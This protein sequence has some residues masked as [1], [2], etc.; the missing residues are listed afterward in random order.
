MN[1]TLN[2]TYE[3]IDLLKVALKSSIV[4]VTRELNEFKQQRNKQAGPTAWSEQAIAIR[5]GAFNKARQELSAV[6]NK[7]DEATKI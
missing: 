5:I 3:E 2:L 1:H 7:L 6:L 4:R